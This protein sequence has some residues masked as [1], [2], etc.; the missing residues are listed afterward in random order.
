MCRLSR[1]R[2]LAK[3]REPRRTRKTQRSELEEGLLF[4]IQ[5]LGIHQPEREYR[6]CAHKVGLGGGIRA[7]LSEAGLKDWHFDFAWPDILFAVEVDGGAWVNGGHNT[8]KG[9]TRDKLK[10]HHAVSQGWQLYRCDAD[11]IKSGLAAMLIEKKVTQEYG[12]YQAFQNLMNLWGTRVASTVKTMEQLPIGDH[13]GAS[14]LEHGSVC[15]ENCRRELKRLLQQQET[16]GG[17]V[18]A[19][20]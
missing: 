11:L 16:L 9:S 8:G 12:K 19:G 2:K 5:A 15:V 14:M 6:F 17:E 13:S 7:R 10:G 3:Y 20:R 4:Q 1:P 18:Y